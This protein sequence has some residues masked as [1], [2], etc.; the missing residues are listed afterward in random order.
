MNINVATQSAG[1]LVFAGTTSSA[2]DI[3]HHVYFA[4]TFKVT[5][6]IATAAVFEVQAA[7]PSAGDPCV[8]GAFVAVPEVP[9]CSSLAVP[10]VNSR[11]TIPIGTP[12]GSLCTATLPCR[13][14]AFLKV[15]AV[16]G[17]TANV[18]V[19]TTLSGPR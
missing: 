16:S 19:V 3:R 2:V 18:Q 11:I 13:P 17:D 1:V 14:A 10:A 7:P 12:I 6:A 15:I 9:I 4:F 8:P 5:A